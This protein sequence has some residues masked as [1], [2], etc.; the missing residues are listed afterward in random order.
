MPPD[1]WLTLLGNAV[2]ILAAGISLRV[3]LEHRI[4]KLETHVDSL[5]RRG[6]RGDEDDEGAT[7]RRN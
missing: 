2:V 3:S 1:F 7:R 5:I 4:T 6:R